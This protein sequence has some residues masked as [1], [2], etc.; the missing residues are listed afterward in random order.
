MRKIYKYPL[1][2]TTSVQTVLMP[3]GYRSRFFADQ[4]GR[5]TVWAEVYPDGKPVEARFQIVFTGGEVDLG[6]YVG[7]VLVDGGN[8]VLHLYDLGTR[9]YPKDLD[10][11]P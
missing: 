9:A 11:N 6:T 7:S 10:P 3:E 2:I 4:H 8:T 5:P 1:Q